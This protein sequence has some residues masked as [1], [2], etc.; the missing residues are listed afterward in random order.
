MVESPSYRSNTPHFH[1][2]DGRPQLAHRELFEH[3]LRALVSADDLADVLPSDLVA[4]DL[5]NVG[6]RDALIAV[7]RTVM[8]SF[9]DER[10]NLGIAAY[11]CSTITLN[12]GNLCD[13]GRSVET[14]PAAA[15]AELR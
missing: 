12:V 1:N 4:H 8:F 7:R 11:E 5:P 10:N 13:T 15:P 3:Y 9:P 2:S 14:L 6:D